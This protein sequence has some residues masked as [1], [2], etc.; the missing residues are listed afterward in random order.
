MKQMKQTHERREENLTGKVKLTRR[1]GHNQQRV[2]L[3]DPNKK[4]YN[5]KEGKHVPSND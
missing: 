3:L 4:R 2:L 5:R 1:T